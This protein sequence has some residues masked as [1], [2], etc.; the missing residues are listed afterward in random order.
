M[1]EQLTQAKRWRGGVQLNK[2]WKKDACPMQIARTTELRLGRTVA[3][4]A[5]R[6]RKQAKAMGRQHRARLDQSGKM[7]HNDN[8]CRYRRFF[9]PRLLY[10]GDESLAKQTGFLHV[11]EVIGRWPAMACCIKFFLVATTCSFSGTDPVVMVGQRTS[12]KI[13]LDNTKSF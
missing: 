10:C 4:R 8:R 1:V 2:E 12:W 9:R 7:L 13:E 6:T 5:R 3:R 11:T